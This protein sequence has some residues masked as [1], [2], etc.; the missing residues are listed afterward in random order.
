M[1]RRN[2]RRKLNELQFLV[3]VDATRQGPHRPAQLY[4][5]EPGAFDAHL[6][7]TRQLPF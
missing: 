3:P 7:R 2:F 5:F 6:A 1:D 4:R